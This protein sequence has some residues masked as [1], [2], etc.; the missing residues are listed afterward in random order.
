LLIIPNRTREKQR[1]LAQS[2]ILNIADHLIAKKMPAALRQQFE[3]RDRLFL[4]ALDAAVD[5]LNQASTKTLIAW[6]GDVVDQWSADLNGTR[7]AARDSLRAFTAALREAREA[8]DR[9][10]QDAMAAANSNMKL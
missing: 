6:P 1:R 5:P 9:Q 10:H 3:N 4:Q 2:I 8:E 7:Q